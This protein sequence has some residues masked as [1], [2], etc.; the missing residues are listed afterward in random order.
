MLNA[1]GFSL[2][3]RIGVVGAA[4]LLNLAVTFFYRLEKGMKKLIESIRDDSIKDIEEDISDTI[5]REDYIE[6][7][8]V[9]AAYKPLNIQGMCSRHTEIS[10]L[11]E[12]FFTVMRL[13]SYVILIIS[14]LFLFICSYDSFLIFLECIKKTCS[15]SS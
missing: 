1:D 7:G 5:N 6:K 15:G 4:I 12:S 13:T 10:G 3:H 9:S 8:V 2:R 14:V 11:L